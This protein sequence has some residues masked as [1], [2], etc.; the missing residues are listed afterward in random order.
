VQDN[1]K[2]LAM[3]LQRRKFLKKKTKETMTQGGTSSQGTNL[4]QDAKQLN[5]V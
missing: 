2:V 5:K 3:P 4:K 1:L